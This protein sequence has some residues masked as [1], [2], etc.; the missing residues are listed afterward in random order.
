VIELLAELRSICS[1][2]RDL[3]PAPNRI[4]VVLAFVRPSADDRAKIVLELGLTRCAPI[5]IQLGRL[6][7]SR[8]NRGT[9]F[10]NV[11]ENVAGG[12]I[13]TDVL[14]SPRQFDANTIRHR[15]RQEIRVRLA[16]IEDFLKR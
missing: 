9:L 12:D 1:A 6:D 4:L 2:S 10:E 13:V 8:Q 11:F 5:L 14:F 15:R 7:L 3:A 16:A